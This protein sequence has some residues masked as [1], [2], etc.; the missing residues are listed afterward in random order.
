MLMP[1]QS[2]SPTT[3][4]QTLPSDQQQQQQKQEYVDKL[5]SEKNSTVIKFRREKSMEFDNDTRFINN[6]NDDINNNHSTFET[7]DEMIK[8][9]SN[10]SSPISNVD[11]EPQLTIQI[12]TPSS[13]PPPPQQQQ[14]SSSSKISLF[15]IKK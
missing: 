8:L 4:I 12:P 13:S 2:P 9:N 3:T 5:N 15:Y 1:S 7:T 10:N 14:I 11:E 6:I